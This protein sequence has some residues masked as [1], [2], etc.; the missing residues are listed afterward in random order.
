[1]RAWPAVSIVEQS[2]NYVI[3]LVFLSVFEWR[4][5]MLFKKEWN[6]S[7]A[8]INGNGARGTL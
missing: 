2:L 6:R 3:S 7:A 1:M 5:E 4:F 8:G